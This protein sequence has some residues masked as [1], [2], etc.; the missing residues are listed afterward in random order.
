MAESKSVV[1]STEPSTLVSCSICVDE[2]QDPRALPCG[3]SYCGPPKKCLDALQKPQ[4]PGVLRCALCNEAHRLKIE[5]LKPLYGFRELLEGHTSEV[6]GYKKEI[7]ELRTKMSEL[8]K[9]C[10]FEP[11]K[12]V[13]TIHYNASGVQFWCIDC[14]LAICEECQEIRHN[15]H[16]VK[17][18]KRY[19]QG[20]IRSKLFRVGYKPL[21]AEGDDFLADIEHKTNELNQKLVK[22]SNLQTQVRV[23]QKS[24]RLLEET[25]HK[26]YGF[27]ENPEGCSYEFIQ[28]F[29]ETNYNFPDPICLNTATQTPREAM[30]CLKLK[31]GNP[32]LMITEFNQIKWSF[33]MSFG[34][35]S[36]GFA[37][38]IRKIAS[39]LHN[40]APMLDVICKYWK[41]NNP[42]KVGIY[43]HGDSSNS[44]LEKIEQSTDVNVAVVSI[45]W[46]RLLDKNQKF[47]DENG[48]LWLVIQPKECF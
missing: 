25:K 34:N 9:K 48:D 19:L 18:F 12:C 33:D 27:L 28:S 22:W 46:A 32:R 41:G 1:S 43:N 13:A 29:L 11:P 30:R 7:E 40:K 42:I 21:S 15:R 14:K 3:H 39:P 16:S 17:S 5:D 24:R 44:I 10:T 38:G 26:L 35:D 8:E 31:F 6:S 2:I 20:E 45:L 4:S 37:L 47:L 23:V 36:S